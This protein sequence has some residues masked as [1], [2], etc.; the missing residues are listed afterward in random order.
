MDNKLRPD[1]VIEFYK[2]FVDRSKLRENLQRIAAQRLNEPQKKNAATRKTRRAHPGPDRP[3]KPVSD[4]GPG[5]EYDP[6]IELYKQDVDR[7][8]L[9]ENLKLTPEQRLLKLNSFM[10]LIAELRS[11]GK[12][13]RATA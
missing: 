1:P 7:T 4:C 6:I 11:A 12:R 3:W 13:A 5:R 8:L 10:R 2:Q 9:R